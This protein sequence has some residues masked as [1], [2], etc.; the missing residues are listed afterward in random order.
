M[1]A[2][3]ARVAQAAPEESA[4]DFIAEVLQN[5]K[6]SYE[7]DRT[8]CYWS[9]HGTHAMVAHVA[10]EGTRTRY[11]YIARGNQPAQ[12]VIETDKSIFFIRPGTQRINE[13]RRMGETD[14]EG[15]RLHLALQNYEWRFEPLKSTRR[16]LVVATRPGDFYPTQRFWVAVPQKIVVRSERYGPRGELRSQWALSDLQFKPNLPDSL[17]TPTDDPTIEIH[18]LPT[19]VRLTQGSGVPSL[20]FQPVP[21]PSESLPPGYQLVERYLEQVRG[22]QAV[23][24]VYSDGL[25]SFSLVE[26]ARRSRSRSVAT[27]TKKGEDPNCRDIQVLDTTVHLLPSAEASTV[28]W[29]DSERFYALVG[30]VPETSLI[31][32]SRGLILGLRPP[33]P[34]APPPPPPTFGQTVVRGWHRLLRWLGLA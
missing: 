5:T 34:P 12:T 8:S 3:L 20:G 16:R 25:H 24:M 14:L 31:S 17:F 19:P 21:L 11:D 32:L 13:A 6:V 22:A 30:S 27:E 7:A 10:K 1:L 2:G 26:T 29:A 4:R 33:T 28:Q 23:R 9:E 18:P 15:V